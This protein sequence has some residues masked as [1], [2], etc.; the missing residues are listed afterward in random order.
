M[1]D[2]RNLYLIGKQLNLI[3]LTIGKLFFFNENKMIFIQIDKVHQIQTSL[4]M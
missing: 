1:V 3:F 2:F 4:K